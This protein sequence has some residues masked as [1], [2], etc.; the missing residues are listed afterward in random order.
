M[1]SFYGKGPKGAATRLHAQLV[2]Q[3][4]VCQAAAAQQGGFIDWHPAC[5]GKLETSHIISRRYSHTRTALDNALCLCSGAHR[6]VTDFHGHHL[7][8][9]ALVYGPGHW[10]DL[11][12][13]AQ[14]T[15]KFD[16]EERVKELNRIATER[17]IT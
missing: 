13:R 12:A 4:G 3:R 6:H 16:W 8:L 17:G 1:S 7:D 14:L 11:Y 15:G 10:A 5:A 9:V 2:R